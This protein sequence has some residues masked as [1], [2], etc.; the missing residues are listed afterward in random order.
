MNMPKFDQICA[1][2]NLVVSINRS[3]VDGHWE[4][5]L[6]TP[7]FAAGPSLNVTGVGHTL[8]EA[9][10]SAV[11]MNFTRIAADVPAEEVE[12]EAA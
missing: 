11:N 7:P 1:K 3:P 6:K 8:A 9:T 2:L 4:V 5:V 10:D 12:E